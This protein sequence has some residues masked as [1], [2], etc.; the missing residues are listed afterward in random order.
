MSKYNS[1]ETMLDAA[2]SDI[3]KQVDDNFALAISGGLDST[4]LILSFLKT[5]KPFIAVNMTED[6][7]LSRKKQEMIFG[8]SMC[9]HLS[10]ILFFP[11]LLIPRGKVV[12]Y[13]TIA[14]YG[15]KQVVTGDGMDKC[16]REYPVRSPTWGL[17]VKAKHPLFEM[18]TRS[19]PEHF[20]IYRH[21]TYIERHSIDPT[22]KML[23]GI[24]EIKIIQISRHP[25]F[26]KFFENYT[27]NIRDL[28]FPKQLTRWYVNKHLGESFMKTAQRVYRLNRPKFESF[29]TRLIRHL[30]GDIVE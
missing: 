4:A 1:F 11:L 9:E 25:L 27:E 17:D 26:E 30:Q 13:K 20:K 6:Y 5:K 3:S 14:K 28:F 12:V 21:T 19:F 16:Y 18:F 8:Q 7:S 24:K 15:F 10:N 22:D 29:G 2:C 23:D